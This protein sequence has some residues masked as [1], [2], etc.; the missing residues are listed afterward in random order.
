MEREKVNPSLLPNNSREVLHMASLSWDFIRNSD[1]FKKSSN[2]DQLAL[3]HNYYD[4]NIAGKEEAPSFDEWVS[5]NL[6]QTSEDRETPAPAIQDFEKD[7]EGV[8]NIPATLWEDVKEAGRGIAQTGVNVLNTPIEIANAGRIGLNALAGTN[9]QPIPEAGFGGLIDAPHKESTKIL[10]D[11]APM[12]AGGLGKGATKV[13]SKAIA[14]A[15]GTS[16]EPEIKDY[17]K[18][19]QELINAEP[20]KYKDTSVEELALKLRDGEW[21]G[22][23]AEQVVLGGSIKATGVLPLATATGGAEQLKQVTDTLVSGQDKLDTTKVAKQAAVGGAFGVL[24]NLLPEAVAAIAKPGSAKRRKVIEDSIEAEQK[25]SKEFTNVAENKQAQ[26]GYA[27]L[28]T[29]VPDNATGVPKQ[30]KRKLANVTVGEHL[31]FNGANSTTPRFTSQSKNNYVL[32]EEVQNIRETYFPNLS[33]GQFNKLKVS[34]VAEKLRT[35]TSNLRE[36]NNAFEPVREDSMLGL[37]KFLDES[38]KGKPTVTDLSKLPTETQKALGMGLPTRAASLLGSIAEGGAPAWVRQASEAAS[39]KKVTNEGIDKLAR[40]RDG[41][42]EVGRTK[43]AQAM[44]SLMDDL[45]EGKA[46]TNARAEELANLHSRAQKVIPAKPGSGKLWESQ[47]SPVDVYREVNAAQQAV[48][49]AKESDKGF[50]AIAGVALPIVTGGSSLWAQVPASFLKQGLDR[51][52]INDVRRATGKTVTGDATRNAI[53]KG[54]DAVSDFMDDVARTGLPQVLAGQGNISSL[55]QSE[56]E[57][58]WEEVTVDDEWE[59]V[60]EDSEWEPVEDDEW[61]EVKPEEKTVG[62]VLYD[63]ISHAE[64]GSV[65]DPWIRTKAQDASSNQHSSAYGPAQITYTLAQDYLTRKPEL[66]TEEE[67]KY[68]ELFIQQGKMFIAASNGATDDP[69]FQYGGSG[70][71]TSPKAK[72]LYKSVA[73]KML[74]DTYRGSGQDLGKTIKSWRGLDDLAYTNKVVNALDV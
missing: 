12:F 6:S 53:A 3:A 24:G 10:A 60:P 11:V 36:L 46:L 29:L 74:T 28:F 66:F 68:L 21:A 58:E 35:D 38:N 48:A 64:T 37:A 44:S 26:E 17:I 27:D 56:P 41:Y 30:G 25:A 50:R 62:S 23:K 42:L 69:R 19:A 71:L 65:E 5:G 14:M 70:V 15:S 18:P 33:E 47:E 72:E 1:S 49:G 57:E 54:A 34:E 32:P 61:E 2:A 52:V 43:D 31:K 22:K 73:Q 13:A 51:S 8:S 7:K 20:E 67:R 40:I 4:K 55:A 63:A 59:E 39:L 9:I 45:R 16:D